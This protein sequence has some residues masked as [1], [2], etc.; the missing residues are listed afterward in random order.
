MTPKVLVKAEEATDPKYGTPP[1]N[2]P[3]REHIKKGIVNLNKPSGPTSH[4][5]SA[6]VRDMLEVEKAGHAGTLDPKVTGVL[7][8]AIEDSTRILKT[9]LLAGKEYVTLMMLHDEVKSSD[10][11]AALTYFQ[12]EIFQKPPLKSNV[13]R[14]IRTKKIYAI[15]LLEK[16]G[17]LVLFT[18]DCE[19]G[20]YIRKLCHDLGLYLGVGAHMQGLRRIRAGPFTEKTSVT[21]HDLKDAYE[22][23]KEDG[24]EKY[25]R[26]CILPVE[27]AAKDLKKIW[28]KDSA[29]SAIC[30]GADL[31]APGIAKVEADIKK[32]EVVALMTLK[33]ELA[34][35]AISALT[36]NEIMSK[37]R[38]KIAK[39][40]RVIMDPDIYPRKWHTSQ[41]I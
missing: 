34:A 35:V 2:R 14:Q 7:P 13:K 16:D 3:L 17:K 23:Y 31:N 28:L 29:V 36:T 24:N 11:K 18:V 40:H 19:S 25:L 6:W 30:H 26:E 37:N 15:K 20:T 21:M 39:L 38:G 1:E 8:I 22:F 10:L 27:Y 12:G 4:Q 5:V 32:G 41:N 33:E 9:L